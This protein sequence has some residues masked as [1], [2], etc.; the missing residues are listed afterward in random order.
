MP[1]D[2]TK[3]HYYQFL[4]AKAYG[5][6][7]QKYCESLSDTIDALPCY[8]FIRRFHLERQLFIAALAEQAYLIGLGDEARRRHHA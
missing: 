7:L 1:V 8:R 4:L 3:R 6:H 2:L 5:G